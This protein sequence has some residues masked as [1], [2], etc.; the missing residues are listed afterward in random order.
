MLQHSSEDL[1]R[2]KRQLKLQSEVV[3]SLSQ[4]VK[5]GTEYLDKYFPNWLEEDLYEVDMDSSNLHI[6]T[7]VSG[8]DYNLIYADNTTYEEQKPE[9]IKCGF[10]LPDEE[11]QL[12]PLLN[13]LWRHEIAM[14]KIQRSENNECND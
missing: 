3:A 14:R 5:L 4:R 2:P 12:Y 6:I 10:L 11:I 1:A 8:I 7:L 9:L 13:E